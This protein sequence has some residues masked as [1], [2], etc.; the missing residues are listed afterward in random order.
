VH[1][2]SAKMGDEKVLNIRNHTSFAYIFWG[3]LFGQTGSGKSS[4]INMLGGKEL[5]I[6]SSGVIGQTFKSDRYHVQIKERLFNVF[7]TAG[8]CEGDEGKVPT[9]DAITSLY[10][11]M[12]ELGDGIS[13]LVFIFRAQ[14]LEDQAVRNYKMFYETFL[15]SQSP[16]SDCSHWP[17]ERTQHGGL[18]VQ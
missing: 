2:D 17:G 11:L 13:L 10:K 15:R 6:T 5:A 3:I 12:N 18:V 4:V 9:K 16:H 7:D 1:N 8:V 14:R